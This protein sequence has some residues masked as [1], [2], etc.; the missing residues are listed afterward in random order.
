MA[1]S[2]KANEVKGDIDKMFEK[3]SPAAARRIDNGGT[4]PKKTTRKPKK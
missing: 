4:R 1:K 2:I 3:L